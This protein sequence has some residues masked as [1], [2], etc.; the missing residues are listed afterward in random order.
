[1][2]DAELVREH[3]GGDYSGG[4]AAYDLARLQGK[5]LLARLPTVTATRPTRASAWPAC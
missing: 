5:G 1:M 2:P 4:Q 3:L